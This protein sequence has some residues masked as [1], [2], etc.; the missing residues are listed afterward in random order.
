[1][2]LTKEV[3][4]EEQE[5]TTLENLLVRKLKLKKEEDNI[6]ISQNIKS[7]KLFRAFFLCSYLNILL[8]I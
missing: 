3:K 7:P 2:K 1:L 5:F 4:L 8:L 6:L